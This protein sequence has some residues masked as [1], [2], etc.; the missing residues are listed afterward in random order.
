MGWLFGNRTRVDKPP[1][2]GHEV[3]AFPR[4]H[5]PPPPREG[6]ATFVPVDFHSVDE[7]LWKARQDIR[8]GLIDPSA[9]LIVAYDQTRRK[10]IWYQ[11]GREDDEA[12]DAFRDWPN[13]VVLDE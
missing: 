1:A 10:V 3:I 2:T 7:V 9:C 6:R 5:V 13:E 8:R 12:D 4:K 11:F